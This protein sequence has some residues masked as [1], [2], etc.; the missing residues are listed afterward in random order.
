MM[1]WGDVAHRAMQELTEDERRSGVVYLDD[2]EPAI[3][4]VLKVDGREIALPGNTVAVFVD[5]T[6]QAN[7]GHAC[8]YLLINREDGKVESIDA[9]FPPFLHGVPKT[10]RVVWKGEAVPDWAVAKP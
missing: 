7:W 1:N 3:D 2:Q 5:K 10:L 6:P 8:R 4:S 9:Q